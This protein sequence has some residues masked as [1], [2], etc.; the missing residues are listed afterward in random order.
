[1]DKLDEFN[2][3][4][5]H[6]E[7]LVSSGP[8]KKA[9]SSILQLA[10]PEPPIIVKNQPYWDLAG[11]LTEMEQ[12]MPSLQK[13]AGSLKVYQ[14]TLAALEPQTNDV[15]ARVQKVGDHVQLSTSYEVELGTW[16]QS[17]KNYDRENDDLCKKGHE[18]T[19]EKIKEF[20]EVLTRL[21]DLGKKS[22]S[23]LDSL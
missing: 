23:F 16:L 21:E 5:T 13:M 4:E 11:A 12:M 22:K 10:R 19:V 9:K 18:D 6:Q 17:H 1:M 14:S 2:Q 15:A 20:K 3:V 8:A 7:D